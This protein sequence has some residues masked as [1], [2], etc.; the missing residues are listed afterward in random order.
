MSRILCVEDSTDTLEILAVVLQHHEL[1][2]AHSVR[3]ALRLVDTE[4]FLLMIL[5]V[6]LPDGSGFEVLAHCQ[7]R[8]KALP[9]ICLTGK[10]DFASKVSAFSLG[11]D[12]YIQKPFDPRELK[13]RVDSKL[14]KVRD[15]KRER[16][17]LRVGDLIFSVED[18]RVR[19]ATGNKPLDL[20]THEYRILYLFARTPQKV[21][22]REE[23]LNRVWSDS[24][25]V[26]D[27]TVDVHVF[28]L[29]R[30]LQ[31]SL[32][33]IETVVG[34]GYSLKVSDPKAGTL[35]N[36]NGELTIPS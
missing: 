2:F 13:L 36:L 25:S 23:I 11:A 24:V 17:A 28:N 7:G 26:T 16:N 15:S 3:E 32:V 27:R 34:T 20:T 31:G 10:K 4:S 6:E 9:V 1:T 22:M 21:F 5:D 30:K 35:R 29:R 33:T 14:R 18:Q 12:D 19:H 8:A